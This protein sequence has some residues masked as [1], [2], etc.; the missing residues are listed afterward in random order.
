MR[1]NICFAVAVIATVAAGCASS[2]TLVA[3]QQASQFERGVTTRA[4]VIAKLG[5]PQQSTKMDDGTRID[6]YVH[7]QASATTATYI[8]VVGLFAGGAKGS[9]NT[10]TFTYGPDGILKSIGTSAGQNNVNTGLLNQN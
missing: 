9:N 7:I 3:E 8:P 4:Q 2:G 1:L 10:A 6:V 5:E